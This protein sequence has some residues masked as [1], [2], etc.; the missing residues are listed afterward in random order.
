MIFIKVLEMFKLS[1][2][3]KDQLIALIAIDYHHYPD[4]F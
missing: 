1:F 3:P 4:S 2:S